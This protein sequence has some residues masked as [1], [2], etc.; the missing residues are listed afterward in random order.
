[1]NAAFPILG[2][3]SLWL[4]GAGIAASLTI[5]VPQTFWRLTAQEDTDGD[6]KITTHDHI[7]PFVIRDETGVA[8]LTLTNVYRLS[9]LLR[10]L[11]Q[12]DNE[13]TPEISIGRIWLA[14]CGVQYP[15]ADPT[16][17]VP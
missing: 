3:A 7:T 6:H 1:M 10:D 5:P 9:V 16:A 14:Q 13:H 8:A 17:T 2:A 15:T 4:C 11:K 12:A